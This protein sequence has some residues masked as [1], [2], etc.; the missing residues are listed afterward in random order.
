M[1][2]TKT[3]ATSIAALSLLGTLAGCAAATDTSTTDTTAADAGSD[4]YTDGDY[5]A[6]GSYTSPNGAEEITVDLTLANDIIT[7]VTVTGT[8]SGPDAVRYQGEF[9]DSIGLV[10]VGKNINDLTVD[11]VAGSS[12][13]STG[14][15]AALDEIKA[16]ALA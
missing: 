14:F 16:D 15:N 13:T 10:A 3:A 11:K 7:A 12:L 2:L 4:V 1:K 6:S 5:S 8:P 9:E